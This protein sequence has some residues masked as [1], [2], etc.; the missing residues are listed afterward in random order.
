MRI[1]H[2]HCFRKVNKKQRQKYRS[3]YD[4]RFIFVAFEFE[5]PNETYRH[6][7]FTVTL[8]N[9]ILVLSSICTNIVDTIPFSNRNDPCIL[10]RGKKKAGRGKKRTS[11]NNKKR[12]EESSE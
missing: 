6:D 3:L 10:Q 9:I 5:E 11:N 1:C 2:N 12:E 8:T 7:K 4:F